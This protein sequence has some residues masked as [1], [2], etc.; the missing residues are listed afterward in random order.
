MS[1]AVSPSAGRVYGVARVC[2]TWGVA[3]S[4]Y[5]DRQRQAAESRPA[6]KRGP[7][8]AWSD[9]E[10][11]EAIR[12]V[13]AESPFVGEGHRKVWARLRML[14]EI[15]TSKARVLRLMR[16]AGL[17][18]TP[19]G[20]RVLGPKAHDGTIVTDVPDDMWG[21]D[22]TRVYTRNDDWVTV[23]IAVDHATSECVG[24][25]AAKIGTRFEA[26]EPIRQGV[27]DRFHGFD[28]AVAAGLTL[29]HDNGSQYT[30]DHFQSE[31]RFLGIESSPSFV[32]SPEGNGCAERF[33]RTLKEQLLWIQSFD[34]VEQL[35]QGLRAWAKLYNETWLVQRHG[36]LTPCQ[37]NAHLRKA[38]SSAA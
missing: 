19:K 3:R 7:K 24:I 33:I 38:V 29:R 22:A 35:R 20:R 5:Y 37:A 14:K 8:T 6:K 26:L 17:L 23:F 21:T 1:H 13:L 11:T 36:H 10:L 32:R 34:D 25:H 15:R 18:A 31:I 12:N 27:R 28:R 16:E 4:T 30:S 2:E 9:A